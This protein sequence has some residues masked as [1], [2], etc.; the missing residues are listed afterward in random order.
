ME[1]IDQRVV[2]LDNHVADVDEMRGEVGVREYGVVGTCHEGV[3]SSQVVQITHVHRRTIECSV[4]FAQH[5]A[6]ANDGVFQK[7]SFFHN[8]PLF[9]R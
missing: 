6:N 4:D 7:C 3:A 2:C 1:H 5:V 8:L 9:S